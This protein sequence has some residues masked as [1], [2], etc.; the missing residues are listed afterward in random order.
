MK[1]K[2]YFICRRQ[3]IDIG[4]KGGIYTNSFQFME[5]CWGRK[6]LRAAIKN[7]KQAEGPD[8]LVR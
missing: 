1:Q 5:K 8:R 2:T 3:Y 6:E 4:P 7:Y